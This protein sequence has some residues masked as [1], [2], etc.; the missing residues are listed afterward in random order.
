MP[1]YQKSKATEH[2]SFFH[3]IFLICESELIQAWKW[4]QVDPMDK[5]APFVCKRGTTQQQIHYGAKIKQWSLIG[6]LLVKC[7]SI[8]TRCDDLVFHLFS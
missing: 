3:Q 8:G 2:I 1:T 4:Y 7:F 5:N 6:Q